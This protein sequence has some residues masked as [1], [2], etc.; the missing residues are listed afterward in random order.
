MSNICEKCGG[1][2]NLTIEIKAVSF[3]QEIKAIPVS[4]LIR[5]CMCS[6]ER[7]KH[8]G[9]LDED[10]NYSVSH[11]TERSNGRFHYVY[12]EG[13]FNL[14]DDEISLTPP[15]ALSLLAWLKQEEAT[16]EQLA[17]EQ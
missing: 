10:E 12:I 4:N 11:S 16:L 14:G 1:A 17:K 2:K 7:E 6:P 3:L 9:K 13:K 8:D 15:Q 5:I